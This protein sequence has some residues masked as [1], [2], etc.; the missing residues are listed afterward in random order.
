MKKK[1]GKM[2][3]IGWIV[4]VL[5]CAFG[6]SMFTKADFGLSMIGAPPYILHY[7]L[8]EMI[9][10]YTQGTSEYFFQGVEMIIMCLIIGRFK[11]KYLLS[12]GSSV[13]AGLTI[14]MWLAILGGNGAYESMIMRIIAFVIGESAIAMAVALFFRTTMPIQ[15]C[16]L[17]VCEIS[18]RYHLNKNKFK[19]WFDVFMMALSCTLAVVLHTGFNGI[20]I[21]TVIV[22]FINAPLITLFGKI[23]DKFFSFDSIVTLPLK[24]R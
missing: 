3:E 1:I 6:V 16:E 8:R 17:V 24:K 7:A 12:F 15:V 2:N 5:L 14:D 9:P 20:G 21:G 23:L 10:W 13:L 4:G 18:E 22:V 19:L 11:P